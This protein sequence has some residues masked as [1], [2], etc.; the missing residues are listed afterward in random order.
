MLRDGF[1]AQSAA[2]G[3]PREFFQL[4][5]CVLVSDLHDII[6]FWAPSLFLSQTYLVTDLLLSDFLAGNAM[7]LSL[8]LYYINHVVFT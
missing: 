4:C 8:I 2:S 7:M 3:V 6:T 1:Y 5:T